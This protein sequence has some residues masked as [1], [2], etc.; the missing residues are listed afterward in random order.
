LP[1]G[2]GGLFVNTFKAFQRFIPALFPVF[3]RLGWQYGL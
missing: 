3:A 1:A 2:R